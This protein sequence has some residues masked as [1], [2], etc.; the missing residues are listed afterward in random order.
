MRVEDTIFD[1]VKLIYPK[2]HYDDRGFFTEK[3]NRQIQEVTG[4]TSDMFV[5]DNHSCSKRGV[6]RGLHYQWDK[7]MGKLLQVIAGSA[8]DVVLDIRKESLTYGQHQKFFLSEENC[9]IVWIPPGFAQGFIALENNTHVFYKT[10]ALYNANADG[11]VNPLDPQLNIDW[12]MDI[13]SLTLSPKDIAAPTF[14]E[15]SKL[16]R[17]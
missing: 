9:A 17:F 7:P 12:T 1:T 4:F 2:V 15:Y 5:Q 8:Y 6:V 13:S 10:T 11:C 16:P 14:E 3:F